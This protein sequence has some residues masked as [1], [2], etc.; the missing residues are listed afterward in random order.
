M[1]CEIKV[2]SCDI[3]LH[4]SL[5]DVNLL[6][7]FQNVCLLVVLKLIYIL[8]SSNSIME[9]LKD[10]KVVLFKKV[11]LFLSQRSL[12][13]LFFLLLFHLHMCQVE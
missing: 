4:C 6:A 12:F 5:G 7:L 3:K 10:T 2:K 11:I 13:C 1:F 9:G 8:F